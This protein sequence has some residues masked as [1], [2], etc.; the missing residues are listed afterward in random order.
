[1]SRG[2]GTHRVAAAGVVVGAMLLLVL[3]ALP[4]AALLLRGGAAGVA[5]LGSDG[6]LRAAL[7]LTAQTATVAT[8]LT[9]LLG[10]P[11]AYLLA[12]DRM[13]AVRKPTGPQSRLAGLHWNRQWCNLGVDLYEMPVAVAAA[14]AV[15]ISKMCKYVVMEAF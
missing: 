5:Q 4:I 15:V 13:P 3:L 6:E 7:W 12:R 11:L 1:V 8:L 2:R 9:V 10:T 14:A